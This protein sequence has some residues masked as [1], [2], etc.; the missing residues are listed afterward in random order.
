VALLR[1]V[2]ELLYIG[3]GFAVGAWFSLRANRSARRARNIATPQ[4]ER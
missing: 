4:V 3:A 2:R 1:R